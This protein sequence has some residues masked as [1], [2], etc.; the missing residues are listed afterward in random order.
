[1]SNLLNNS[2]DKEIGDNLEAFQKDLN[3]EV[4]IVN[5]NIIVLLILYI[6]SLLIILFFIY[7]MNLE[8]KTLK[9][10]KEHSDKLLLMDSLT[11]LRGMRAFNLDVVKFRHPS[12]ILIN[13]DRFKHI[14]EF[15]GTRMGDVLLIKVAQMLKLISPKGF[16]VY[17]LGGDD[18]GILFENYDKDVGLKKWVDFYIKHTE[19]YVCRIDG[20]SI[21]PRFSLGAS[22]N[23]NRIFETADMALRVAKNISRHKYMIYTK[24][25]DKMEEIKNNIATIS[26]IS[27]ALK[28]NRLKAYYQPVFNI[29]ADKIEKYEALARI[30]LKDGTLLKPCDFMDPAI[31]AKLRGDITISIL[32]Q[33][34]KVARES[35]YKFSVN[36]SSGDIQFYKDREAIM[37][38]LKENIDIAHKIIF[39]ILESEEI[40]DYEIV[41][42][43][44]KNIKS[45][46]CMV[47]IDDF[48]SGYIKP[49][50]KILNFRSFDH[51]KMVRW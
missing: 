8:N 32:K 27:S 7:R 23:R 40:D 1:L 42:D 25:I 34:I 50:E 43:F 20:I 13:I 36:V 41:N 14:N 46:G 39:E 30:E 6:I 4:S 47:A 45:F 10:L 49:S 31:E 16:K 11:G 35:K 9:N 19:N 24:N 28:E 37:E 44:I 21:E 29:K 12:L 38:L 48:G 33:I 51:Y 22:S 17:R 15:Y 3:A 2:F 18:F 5:K 26:N